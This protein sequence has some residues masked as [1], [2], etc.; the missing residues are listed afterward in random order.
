MG[1]GVKTWIALALQLA[2]L[3]NGQLE[4]TQIFR[5]ADES[6]LEKRRSKIADEFASEKT[7]RL[8]SNKVYNVFDFAI[9]R[10]KVIDFSHNRRPPSVTSYFRPY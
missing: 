3:L 4:F 6:Q 7:A 1:V 5:F 8:V 2:C 10:L 9:A